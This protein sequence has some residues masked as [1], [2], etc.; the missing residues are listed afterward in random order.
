MRQ[1]AFLPPE[2]I[3]SVLAACTDA[4]TQILLAYDGVHISKI[5]KNDTRRKEF[6]CSM[7]YLM[8]TGVDSRGRAVL[9]C[10]HIM[11]DILPLEIFLPEHFGIR[12]KSITEGENVLKIEMQHTTRSSLV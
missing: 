12:A 5:K 11:H 4:I 2:H 1:P 10:M 3:A 8:R 6:V 7:L 9:P